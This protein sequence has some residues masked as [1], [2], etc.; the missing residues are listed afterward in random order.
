M[1]DDDDMGMGDIMSDQKEANESKKKTQTASNVS[2]VTLKA[3]YGSVTVQPKQDC[4]F[5]IRD[6][7]GALRFKGM[8]GQ[9]S[10]ITSVVPSCEQCAEKRLDEARYNFED[11][12]F[13]E[14]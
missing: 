1:S 3:E 9:G 12:M 8:D 14:F 2:A 11:A 13:E 5:C 7:D 4:Q 6:A 10:K